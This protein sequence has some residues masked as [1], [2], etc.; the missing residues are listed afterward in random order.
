VNTYAIQLGA[1]LVFEDHRS[2]L[3]L[4]D[5]PSDRSYELRA[6]VASGDYFIALATRLDQISQH[7]DDPDARLHLEQI[8]ADLNHLYTYYEVCQKTP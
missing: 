4:R 8:I 5:I 2:A 1:C 3:I 6:Q 7:L